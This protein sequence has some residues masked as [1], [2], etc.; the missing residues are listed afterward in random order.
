MPTAN[1]A[2][3]S[4]KTC[5]RMSSDRDRRMAKVA[6]AIATAKPTKK[7]P[8]RYQAGR[9]NAM[10]KV[11]RYRLI[12]IIHSSGPGF[13]SVVIRAVNETSTLEATAGNAT[14]NTRSAVV[15]KGASPSSSTAG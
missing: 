15:G 1:T 8:R 3:E 6:P 7:G 9:S 12:G 11:T 4:N 2:A 13:T 14:H 10:M 5:Q